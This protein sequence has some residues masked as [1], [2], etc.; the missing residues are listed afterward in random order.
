MFAD[1]PDAYV[2]FLGG[3]YRGKQGIR[4]L[5]QGLF[6]QTFVKGRN[7]PV[8]GFLL[9]RA[10][11]QD[12][13]DVD[14]AGRHAWVRMRALMSA[15]THQSVDETH[16]RGHVQWWEGGLYENE[17]LKEG[18]VWKLFRYRYFPFWHG[19]LVFVCV[20]SSL[21][22]PPGSWR[23]CARARLGRP[24]LNGTSRNTMRLFFFFFSI[25]G[26]IS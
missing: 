25:P 16:P 2:E 15:G 6:Q 10:M 13:V 8:H 7:G 24:A 11:L 1:H 4:R 26:R 20:F 23:L 12:I 14:A 5:Y 3:R 21:P 9:D 17:Y 19:E 22:P 18:G